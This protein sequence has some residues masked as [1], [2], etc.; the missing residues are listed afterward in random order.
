MPWYF[1]NGRVPVPVKR[2]DGVVVSV[3][4]RGYVEAKP[5]DV[6]KF[7]SKM[8]RCAAPKEEVEKASLTPPTEVATPTKPSPLSEAIKEKGVTRDPKTPPKPKAETV[9]E[10][11]AEEK[12]KRRSRSRKKTTTKPDATGE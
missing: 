2:V 8:R 5:Q 1:Y 10:D 4:P 9:Q 7:G 11:A 12:P 6:R 3:T